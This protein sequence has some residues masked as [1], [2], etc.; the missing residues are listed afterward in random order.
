M[1]HKTFPVVLLISMLVLALA[2]CAPALVSGSVT[3]AS[4]ATL[5]P[6]S[7]P[8][9]REA[10]IDSVDVQLSKSMPLQANV[11][12]H[13]HLTEA[14]AQLSDIKQRYEPHEFQIAVLTT[15]P[16]DRGCAQVTTAFEKV[17]PLDVTNLPAGV[18][19]VVVNGVRGSFRLASDN[20]PP[21]APTATAPAAPTATVTGSINGWLWHDACPVSGQ[22]IGVGKD[23]TGCVQEGD[24]YRA[25]GVKEANEA[26]VPY[27]RV[28]LGVGPCPSIGSAETDTRVA[29][30]SYSFLGLNAGT[31][32][33]SIDPL[34][35]SNSSILKAGA[36]SYPNRQDGMISTTVQLGAG[37]NKFD[38]NF[39]WDYTHLPSTDPM[40][41]TYHA[42]FL[43]DV[44]VPDNTI[45]T[46]GESFVKTWRLRNDGDCAWGPGQ[47]VHTLVFANGDRLGAP[48]EVPLTQ[49]VPPGSSVDVSIEMV[50]PQLPGTYRSEWMLMIAEGPLL[51]VG[52][53]G[54]TPI[55][56]QIVVPG[57]ATP[58]PTACTY[59]AAFLGD[60]TVPDNTVVAPGAA[61]VKTWRLRND[62]NCAWGPGQHLHSLAFF[63]GYQLGVPDEVLLLTTV[64]PGDVGDI[65]INMVAPQQ[66]GTYRSGWMLM[67]AEGPLLG[68]GRD[69]QTPL[70]VQIV[71]SG[72]VTPPPKAN[73]GAAGKITDQSIGIE[74]EQGSGAACTATSTYFVHAA[75]TADG[76]TTASYE[77]G[78]TAGQIPAGNFQ[79]PDNNGLSPFITGAVVFDR[80]GTK[81]IHLRFVG[82]YPY[83]NDITVN[84]RVNGGAWINTKLSCQS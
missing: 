59:R 17:I 14:C 72:V 13:G 28:N 15:S 63:N 19:T 45:M 66:P 16:T 27:V 43:G 46:P 41:C 9:I 11:V 38:V 20:V 47:Y 39:G 48:D 3:P 31:Y 42:V 12:A 52:R 4:P 36:W 53:N 35:A 68:V 69:G 75:I 56:A 84:L 67:V 21:V 40:A 18:Y 83:P 34:T 76:P 73:N 25:N 81:T 49:N 80:A 57:A 79:N 62:G 23:T 10:Q 65:S 58:P 74:L 64:P 44:T 70:Y 8:A 77:I 1:L 54:Q 71:V 37:E 2:A 22:P 7:A 33:V 55:Y 29:D 78:S 51:G 5:A 26:I 60:V 6:T 24:V 50:A 30:L 82:P 61:F 32:C